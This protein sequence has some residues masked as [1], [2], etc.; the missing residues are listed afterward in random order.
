[1]LTKPFMRK[2]MTQLHKESHWAPQAMCDAIF[3]SC[4]C[5]GINMVAKQVNESC[6]TYNSLTNRQKEKTSTR[7]RNLGLREFQSKAYK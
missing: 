4:S 2:I 7:R 6:I 3:K 1:M 5:I